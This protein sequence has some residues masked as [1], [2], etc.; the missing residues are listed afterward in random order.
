[1]SGVSEGD[2]R[3]RGIVVSALPIGF[4]LSWTQ[5]FIMHYLRIF[6]RSLVK[7]ADKEHIEEGMESD[8]TKVGEDSELEFSELTQSTEM[9]EAEYSA[10]SEESE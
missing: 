1:M 5:C 7:F 3:I 9:R 4:Q 2:V 10:E 8:T 6:L